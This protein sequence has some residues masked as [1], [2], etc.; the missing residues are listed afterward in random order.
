MS[1]INDRIQEV[2]N[3]T[4]IP[5]E[6]LD[7]AE[8]SPLNEPVVSHSEQEDTGNA[9]SDPG[10]AEAGD[11]PEEAAPKEPLDADEQHIDEHYRE[12]APQEEEFE[13]PE[14]HARQAADTILGMADNVLEVGGGFFVKIKKHKEFYEFE[15]IIQVIDRQNEK[16][17]RRIKLDE[18]DKVLLRPLLVA[19][20]KKKAQKLTPEQMLL[21]ALLS[22]IMKKGQAVLEIKAE[23][24]ILVE[25]ILDIIREEKTEIIPAV[26]E[27]V[28]EQEEPAEPEYAQTLSTEPEPVEAE[29]METSEE[30]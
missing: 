21:G 29:V 11:M 13:I 8:N 9:D 27:E 2:L 25:R 16:N 24:E 15:E 17:I 3:N 30:P 19:V 5:F 26:A 28:E 18:E 1:E 12:S 7:Q 23:N 14:G 10:P 4:D 6:E 20:L 22:I